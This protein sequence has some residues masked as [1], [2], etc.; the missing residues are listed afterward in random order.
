MTVTE[1]YDEALQALRGSLPEG[2]AL[3]TARILVEDILGVSRTSMLTHPLKEIADESVQRMRQAVNRVLSGE[4]VQ[5][6][7]GFQEFMGMRLKVNPGVLIPRPETASLVDAVTDQ[8]GDATDLNVLDVGTGSGCIALALA[9][10]LKFPTVIATDISEAALETA[11]DNARSLGVRNVTFEQSDALKPWPF[12]DSSFDIVISNP[13]Y[14][15]ER[16]RP[17]L[18]KRVTEHEPASALFVPDNDPLLFYRAIAT[19]GARV[20]KPGGYIFFEGNPLTLN[21][22]KARMQ[23]SEEWENVSTWLDDEGRL[24]FLKAQKAHN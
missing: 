24:R 23:E 17:A 16:E 8:F 18:D 2:E 14:V 4:P 21:D 13:P 5:Y 9:R 7:V 1:V 19:E 22:L 15:L 6:V 10:R 3:W 11:R 12:T 20:L